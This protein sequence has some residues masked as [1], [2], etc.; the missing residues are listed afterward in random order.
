MR[1]AKFKVQ[2]F[3]SLRNTGE[4]SLDGS[5]TLLLGKNE[6]GK[7]NILRALESFDSGRKYGVDDL[8]NYSGV[9]GRIEARGDERVE[10]PLV[11]LWFQVED[12]DRNRLSEADERLANV[13]GV[14]VTKDLAGHLTLSVTPKSLQ[15]AIAKDDK[16]VK[17]ARSDFLSLLAKLDQELGAHGV[18]YEPFQESIATAKGL[19]ASLRDA[20]RTHDKNVLEALKGAADTLDELPNQ[21]EPIRETITAAVANLTA[22]AAEGDLLGGI[23]RNIWTGIARVLPRFVYFDDIDR[24]E[25][26]VSIKE[27]LADRSKH[28]TLASL[29]SLVGLDV[30]RLKGLSLHSRARATRVAS[31]DITGRMNKSWTQEQVT[32]SINCDGEQLFVVVE[33]EK[34]GYDP[35]SRRSKGF[36]WYLGFYINFHA[37]A[38]GEL[39]NTI[40]L[41]DD[42]GVYLHPA[43]QRDLLDTIEAL[44]ASNQFVIATH[45]PFLID[46]EHLGRIR[47]VEK[48]S[49]QRGTT[50]R[51][52][53]YESERDA[54]API[55]AAL[56]MTLGDSLALGQHN[57]VVEGVNDLYMLSGMSRVCERAGC[58]FLDAGKI[59]TLPVGGAGNVP[60]F[61][62]LLYKERLPV[63]AILD[64]DDEGRRAQ[65]RMREELGLPEIVAMTLEAFKSGDDCQD[66]ELEDLIDQTAYHQ[67][68]IEVYRSFFEGR[69]LAIP[70]LASMPEAK[71]SRVQPY[72]SY[73]K[74]KKLGRFD[75]T[76][77]ARQFMVA[78]DEAVGGLQLEQTTVDNFARLFEEVGR[79]L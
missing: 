36:Q 72:Q 53:W 61:T 45:S 35:P 56:G 66:V 41:L 8:C 60:Y 3:L 34:G 43:G 51:E 42:P 73:F 11:T 67:A 31:S 37:G 21:D 10:V 24:L 4:V 47:I 54:F 5:V 9:R 62:A 12:Q 27:F 50:L 49:E 25:D 16:R 55:R 7:T 78:C 20:V 71:Y 30:E 74:Q 2:D 68:F 44:S 57:V 75:K 15:N 70:D 46:R 28:K 39:Q 63:L 19:I 77:V 13:E 59:S 14:C 29:V 38:G 76:S 32:V 33:D 18:R 26:S 17:G 6:H 64:H 69:E 1:I 48:Q 65:Q 40:L 22:V 58:A 23:S 79:R 52:K